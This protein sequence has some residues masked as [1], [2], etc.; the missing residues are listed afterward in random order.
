MRAIL[1]MCL[2]IAAL[3]A[4][5]SAVAQADNKVR[6]AP[7]PAGNPERVFTAGS[8]WESEAMAGTLDNYPGTIYSPDLSFKLN[9]SG[10]TYRVQ[11]RKL[12]D[13]GIPAIYEVVSVQRL[14]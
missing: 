9:H 13:R 7:V 8:R 6:S 11:T 3:L 5:P 12:N 1:S 2:L 10:K 4:C 14:D